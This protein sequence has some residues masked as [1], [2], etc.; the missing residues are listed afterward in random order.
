MDIFRSDG[1]YYGSSAYTDSNGYYKAS[2]P[3]GQYKLDFFPWFGIP[4][5]HKWFN[6]KL[7]WSS[8]DLVSVTQ[9]QMTIADGQLEKAGRI[10]GKVTDLTSGAGIPNAEVFFYI[11]DVFYMAVGAGS[12]GTYGG[13]SHKGS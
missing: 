7:D 10:A 4:Y 1:T 5:A 13:T 9:N 2:V 8:A 3:S 6:N 12:D 11:N